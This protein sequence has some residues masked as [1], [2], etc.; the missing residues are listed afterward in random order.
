MAL[1]ADLDRVYDFHTVFRREE[2]IDARHLTE[3]R[4][5]SSFKIHLPSRLT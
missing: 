1:A 5:P 3:V 4:T 2:G